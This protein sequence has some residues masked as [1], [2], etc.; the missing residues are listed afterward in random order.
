MFAVRLCEAL[1]FFSQDA[2]LPEAFS[3]EWKLLL[4]D[5]AQGE[6]GGLVCVG[7]HAC[8]SVGL[9]VSVS[10][11]AHMHQSYGLCSQSS[12]PVSHHAL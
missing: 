2:E 11:C 8:V 1:L 10:V 12:S 9:C 7:A 6:E 4:G 5:L 3:P